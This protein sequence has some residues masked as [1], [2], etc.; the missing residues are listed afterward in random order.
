MWTCRLIVTHLD[1]TQT[2]IRG[3]VPNIEE[4]DRQRRNGK[5]NAEIGRIRAQAID[6][7]YRTVVE[8]Y[9]MQGIVL[10]DLAAPYI[11]GAESRSRR[12]I[13]TSSNQTTNKMLLWIWMS[14]F[15]APT[16]TGLRATRADY[17][18]FLLDVGIPKIIRLL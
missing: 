4:L 10:K 12:Y 18:I 7:L 17:L 1:S 16:A 13:G 5:S 15:W 11:F 2:A 9:R 8:I 14:L 6:K 3:N